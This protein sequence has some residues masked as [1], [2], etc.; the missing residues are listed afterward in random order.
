MIDLHLTEPDPDL[1]D[2]RRRTPPGMMYWAG[3]GPS[4]KTCSGCKHFG[5]GHLNRKEKWIRK[6]R[7]CA[8]YWRAM[9]KHQEPLPR[10]TPACKYF[11]AHGAAPVAE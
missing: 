7:G 5:Y 6:P 8:L 3:S 4:G 2:M 11:Q 9:G 1:A 10:E